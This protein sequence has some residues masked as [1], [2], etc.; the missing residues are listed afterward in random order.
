[1]PAQKKLSKEDRQKREIR[2]LNGLYT[3]IGVDALKVV[4]SLI[5]NAAFM[6]ITLED[7]QD[8]INIH[9]VTSEYQNG[10]NQY[11]TK[12]SPEVEIHISMTKNHCQVMKQLSDLL[13]KQLPVKEK[14]D[15]FDDF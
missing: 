2:R 11:G 5:Q 12:K 4:K 15:D 8:Y 10:E 3:N 6:S 13:P 14:G 7:L 1:M 9:G